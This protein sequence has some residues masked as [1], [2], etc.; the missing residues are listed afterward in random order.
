MRKKGYIIPNYHLPPNENDT[1]LL[2][3]VV[4]NTLS[5]NLLERLIKDSTDV[6]ELLFKAADSVNAIASKKNLETEDEKR[7]EIHRLLAI[8]SSAGD[9]EIRKKQKEEKHT[10]CGKDKNHIE[11]LVNGVLVE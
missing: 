7:E 6:A 5:L 3:V 11:V 1:E 2:R 8:I 9:V 4:R 10:D